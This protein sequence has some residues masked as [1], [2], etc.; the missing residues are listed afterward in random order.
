MNDKEF[1]ARLGNP[2]SFT[3]AKKQFERELF[4]T[5]LRQARKS[6]SKA[7]KLLGLSYQT[8]IRRLAKH[9]GLERTPIKKRHRSFPTEEY[10]V[11]IKNVGPTPLNVAKVISEYIPHQANQK[12]LLQKLASQE[13]ITF[14][15]PSKGR[16]DHII[17]LLRKHK[18]AATLETVPITKPKSQQAVTSR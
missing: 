14:K 6:P 7:A 9:E 3:N 13:Q 10:F 2:P 17:K 18:A 4:E 11:I 1:K 15:A 5:A 16:A 8:F 12:E